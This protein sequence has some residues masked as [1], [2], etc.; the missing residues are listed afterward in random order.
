M[1]VDKPSGA[2][3]ALSLAGHLPLRCER[4]VSRVGHRAFVVQPH[5]FGAG[6]VVVWWR[7]CLKVAGIGGW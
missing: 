5:V 1:V 7:R 2:L 3:A 6:G 4:R